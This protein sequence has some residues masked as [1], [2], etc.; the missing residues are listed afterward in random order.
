M[1]TGNAKLAQFLIFVRHVT[2]LALKNVRK[3][4]E[5]KESAKPEQGKE[6]PAH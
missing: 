5:R 3:C 1:K 6:L 4:H 2:T